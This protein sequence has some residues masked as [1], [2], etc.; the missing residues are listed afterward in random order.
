MRNNIIHSVAIVA[1]IFWFTSANDVLAQSSLWE[2]PEGFVVEEAVTDLFLPVEIAFVPNSSPGQDAPLY[3]ITELYGKVKVVLRSGEVRVY[4]DN[5][6]NFSPTGNFPGSGEIGVNGIVVDPSTGDLFVTMVYDDGGIKNKVVRMSSTDGGRSVANITILLDNIPGPPQSHQIHA[7]TIGPDNKLY[8]QIGDGF[9]QESAQRD[10]DLRGKILRLNLDGS[11]PDDNPNANSYVYAKGLRNPFGGAWRKADGFLYVSDN[12]PDR[13]D[14][15]VKVE[16]G[17]NLGWPNTLT[18]AAIKLWNPPVAPTAVAFCN[19]AGFPDSLQ[20]RLFVGLSGPT[21]HLG[22]TTRGKR[23]EMFTLG[24][25]GS[26]TSEEVFLKYI[27][28][29]RATVVGLAF[30][31]DGLYFTDL[32]GEAGFDS[33]GLTRANVYKISFESATTVEEDEGAPTGFALAQN[34]PNPFNPTTVISYVLAKSS[35][36]ELTIYNQLGQLVKTLVAARQPAGA[37]EISWGGRD[38]KGVP[39]ASGT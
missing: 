19:G 24:E 31:P 5:L 14:R 8:V 27:G 38:K 21:Y 33:N 4:A 12:G 26:V 37:Y 35:D 10:D 22:Q 2:V 18:A 16:A 7:A 34:Y 1:L 25:N 11:I 30:G 28:D 32:Y 23:I 9:E 13:N 15:L 17:G 36:V 39:V 20:G 6:L 29:G 3:Y